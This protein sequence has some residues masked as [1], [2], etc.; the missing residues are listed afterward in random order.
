MAVHLPLTPEAQ[1]EARELMATSANMLNPSN[2]EPIVSPTQDMIL[3]CYFL[4][5]E[6]PNSYKG[7]TFGSYD[8]ASI[9]F[10]N[11]DITL[12]TQIRVRGWVPLE[13]DGVFMT[14]GRMRFNA[15]L[16]AGYAFQNMTMTKKQLSKLLSDIFETYGTEVTAKVANEIKN[17]GFKYATMSGLSISE[18]DMLTPSNKGEILEKATEKVRTIQSMA[19][20]GFMTNEER[21]EQSIRIWSQAKNT[22][23]AEMKKV[24]PKENH[25]YH[26]IDSGARGSWGNVTQLCGMKGLV[27]SP[28]GKTIELPI[29]S[30][31]KEGLTALEYFI[32]THGGRKGKADTAL[33]TAQSGYMTRRLVDAAQNI[34]VR[35]ND[36][37]TL[38]FEDI[39]R[40]AGK[41]VVFQESFEERIYGKILSKDLIEGGK[42]LAKKSDII[43]QTLLKTILASKVETVPVRTI[44]MCETHEGVCQHCYGMDL[45]RNRI[46]DIGT[47]IGIVAAQ[48][49]G[50]P[51]TQLTMRTFHTGGAV[52]EGGDITTGLTR[53]EELFE[54][55][56]PKYLAKISHIDGEVTKIEH[57]KTST[58][59]SVRAYK[60]ETREYYIPHDYEQEVKTG[61]SI[62]VKQMLARSPETKQKILATTGGVV[63]KVENGIIYVS[64]TE[65]QTLEYIIPFGRKNTIQ[66]GDKVEKGDKLCEGNIDVE[67]LM[68]VAGP[69]KAQQYIVSAVKEIYASQGQTVNAKHISCIIRQM[70]SK[71]TIIEPGDSEFFQ[72]DTIDIG[73]FNDSNKKLVTAGKKQAIG[74][75]LVLGIAKVSLHSDS[76][77]SA[78]SFQETVKVL[79][80]AASKR[81][82]DHLEDIK[83]NVI[84]GRRIPTLQYFKNNLEPDE[85]YYEGNVTDITEVHS[86]HALVPDVE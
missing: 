59:V 72:G 80:D 15:A 13:K 23:E 17:L 9:A 22:I 84:I 11:G 18:S 31:F 34:L 79:V 16:P 42:T 3:G 64:D 30:N 36:C 24:F 68:T 60:P 32:A 38:H 71:V 58:T 20:E 56:T 70:F 74:Q 40:E 6:A 26:F 55:R 27:A 10:L 66:K 67:E 5:K 43:D 73:I 50:E 1:K 49:I 69:A 77:L 35:E 85:E 29:K 28:S 57:T 78:A 86:A 83:S 12:H 25:I 62:K 44:L 63:S 7:H 61:E 82:I 14:Y 37:G 51:G 21:Y 65:A 75:R 46:V 41:S 8:D 54:A 19:Y 81:R 4:T 53:V 2:G 33:K 76:W 52:K 45:A 39:P 48:S 47:P